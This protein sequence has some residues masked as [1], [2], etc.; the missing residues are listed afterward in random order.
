ME[1]KEWLRIYEQI[2]LDFGFS[3]EKDEE[4]AKLIA[5]L[6]EGKLLDCKV[7]ECIKGKEI[8][9]V[10]GAYGGGEIEEE[11]VI[12]AGKA[13]E[14]I[15]QVPM[16]HVTDLE[17]SLEKILELEKAGCIL[18]FHAHGDNMDRIRE[19]VPK[20]RK[21]V[22]TTQSKPFDRVYNFGGFTDGDR[23]VIIAK[24]F[25]AKKITLYGFDFE[26]GEG[27]KLKKLKWAKKILEIEGIIN[28]P[29]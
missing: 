6:G 11:F 15:G 17:E 3:R 10:G 22:A 12:T 13:V 28:A 20:V 1:L 25:G 23:A 14:K 2:L 18:V 4:S 24:N 5:K 27:L 16:V 21:F 9:V 7:L 29:R 8:A 26:K 19:V